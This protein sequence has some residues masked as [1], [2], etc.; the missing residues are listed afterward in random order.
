MENIINTINNLNFSNI[1]PFFGCE[2]VLLFVF[3]INILL[4]LFCKRKA[5]VKKLSDFTVAIAFL[6]NTLICG[7]VYFLNIG[8][9]QSET[10]LNDFL[11]LNTEGIFLKAVV[12]ILLLMFL[13]ISSRLIRQTL[14]KTPLVNANLCMIGLFSC[15]LTQINNDIL[16]FLLLDIVVFFIY[17]YA[18]LMKTKKDGFFSP[19]FLLLNVISSVVFYLTITILRFNDSDSQIAI[20]NTVL[21]LAYLLKLGI[22]PSANYFS[23]SNHKKNLPYLVL[24]SVYLPFLGVIGL[25]KIFSNIILSGDIFMI[26]SAIFLF[27]CVF[28]IAILT[29]KTKNI[30]KFFGN[31]GL[32]FS[33]FVITNFLVSINSYF[34]LKLASLFAFAMF[35]VFSLIAIFKINNKQEKLYFSAF[36]GVFLKNRFYTFLFSLSILFLFSIIPSALM[37]NSLIALKNIYS[38]DKFG[39]VLAFVLVFCYLLFLLRAFDLIL[40]CYNYDKNSKVKMFIKK[41]TSNYAVFFMAILFLIFVFVIDFLHYM[42]H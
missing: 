23:I 42:N 15:F 3:F 19:D 26:T 37:T 29:L 16:A 22:F 33:I 30:T 9:Y 10:Y 18:S 2:S 24:L 28:N 34:S 38:Y 8:N 13:F 11:Y 17:K 21:F 4:F 20:L 31:L 32:F 1:T 35:A 39:Y 41:T 40:N 12:N 7:A 27:L 5:N 6:I 25:I 14:F 36:R